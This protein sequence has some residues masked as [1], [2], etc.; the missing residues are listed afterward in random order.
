MVQHLLA[1]DFP[2][3]LDEIMDIGVRRV[4]PC[5]ID[6][7]QWGINER[8]EDEARIGVHILGGCTAGPDPRSRGNGPK[9]VISVRDL[10]THLWPNVRWS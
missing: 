1:R 8:D 10:D 7:S 3:K 2:A 6:S 9:P 4:D 5:K